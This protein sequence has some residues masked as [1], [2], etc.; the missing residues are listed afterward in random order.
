ML[1]RLIGTRD[2]QI[3]TFYV[4]P[5]GIGRATMLTNDPQTALPGNVSRE[6]HGAAGPSTQPGIS[7]GAEY[8]GVGEQF[9]WSI[10]SK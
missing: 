6:L 5:P 7:S 1:V 3:K 10:N 8:G 9:C 2:Y 4:P